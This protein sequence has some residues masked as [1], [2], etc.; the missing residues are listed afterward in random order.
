VNYVV[1]SEGRKHVAMPERR[2]IYNV[3]W[4]E[5]FKKTDRFENLGLY[6]RIILKYS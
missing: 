2:K 4:L 6:G 1:A 3:F 5:N